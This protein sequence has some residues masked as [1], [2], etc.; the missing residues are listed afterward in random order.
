MMTATHCQFPGCEKSVDA[1][2]YCRGCRAMICPDH[3]DTGAGEHDPI[4]HAECSVC[5]E[6]GH[7]DGDC[8]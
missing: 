8:Q 3:P 1:D 7:F 6:P 2:Q 4:D 5:G